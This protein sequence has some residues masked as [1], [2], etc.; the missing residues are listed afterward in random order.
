MQR[1]TKYARTI[2]GLAAPARAI[3]VAQPVISVGEPEAD[4]PIDAYAEAP[5][6]APPVVAMAKPQQVLSV[7]GSVG[8]PPH[9]F[10][11]GSVVLAVAA[12]GAALLTLNA[13]R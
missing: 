2:L 11:R 7:E 6:A 10:F 8:D 5:P 9:W 3:V 4:P 12:I 13:G 1:S